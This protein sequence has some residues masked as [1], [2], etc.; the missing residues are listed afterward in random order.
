M[1]IFLIILLLFPVYLSAQSFPYSSDVSEKA[2][3]SISDISASIISDSFAP[4]TH[5]SEEDMTLSLVPA[6]FKIEK[7]MQDPDIEGENFHGGAF[8]AGGGYAFS[9]DLMSYVI[10]SGMKMN[11]DMRYAAYGD[12][13]GSVTNSGDYSLFSIMAGGGYDLLNNDIFSIPLYFGGQMQYY[14]AEL[15]SDSVDWTYL[16]TPYKV[17]MKTSGSGFLYGVS[18]GIG[19]SAKIYDLFKITPY[20][21]YL[22]NFNSAEMKSDIT[23]NNAGLPLSNQ[24]KFDVDP[25]SAGM[26][27]LNIKFESRSGYSVSVALGSMI[28]ALTGYGSEASANGVEMK[29]A[30]LILSYNR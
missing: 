30:V 5:Y 24:Y 4:M 8:G 29:S 20:Y 22:Q 21:L 7:C 6:Y 3:K 2:V 16:A 11:G 23:L 15:I 18:G 17:S 26:F 14:S 10:L 1:K 13:F 9:D 27:G 25:V 12:Q 28:S 19:F